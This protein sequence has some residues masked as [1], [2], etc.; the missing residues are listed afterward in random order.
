MPSKIQPV[1]WL[2]VHRAC[3]TVAQPPTT[4]STADTDHS[5]ASIV[6]TDSSPDL[7]SLAVPVIQDEERSNDTETTAEHDVTL[8]KIDTQ[9]SRHTRVHLV[10]QER[11]PAD[12]DC[13][14][15]ARNKISSIQGARTWKMRAHQHL[16]T[17]PNITNP[18]ED[19]VQDTPKGREAAAPAAVAAM[20]P[21]APRRLA[22]LDYLVLCG[23][24]VVGRRAARRRQRPPVRPCG[25][26]NRPERRSGSAQVL[27][28]LSMGSCLHLRRR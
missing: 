22:R 13:P 12:T 28:W 25:R 17:I 4:T 18:L 5:L 20:G 15:R 2:L 23:T 11:L 9:V 10:L 26:W 19:K 7:Q 16:S 6:F 14:C 27:R 21:A 8:H 24:V 3:Q 1:L